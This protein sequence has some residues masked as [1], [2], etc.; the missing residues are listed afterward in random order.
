MVRDI[1]DNNKDYKKMHKDTIKSYLRIRY[2]CSAYLARK[3]IE[4]LFE[5]S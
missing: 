2:K 3:V 5:E 4:I 1:K